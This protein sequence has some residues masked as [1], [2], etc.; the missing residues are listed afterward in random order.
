LGVV[1]GGAPPVDVVLAGAV[2][3]V[4]VEELLLVRGQRLERVLGV[5]QTVALGLLRG[6]C[7]LELLAL[8][9]ELVRQLLQPV[10]LAG[11]ALRRRLR[12]LLGRADVLHVLD[13]GDGGA[14]RVGVAVDVRG[15]GTDDVAHPFRF[16]AGGIELLLDGLDLGGQRRELLRRLLDL[17]GELG[18]HLLVLTHLVGQGGE[19]VGVGL[20]G[21]RRRRRR[22]GGTGRR[23]GGG[24][25]RRRGRGGRRLLRDRGG[26]RD[27]ERADQH[28]RDHCACA[29]HAPVSAPGPRSLSA[30][31]TARLRPG[32]SSS[33]GE[34][35]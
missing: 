29:E 35:A 12:V 34:S 6:A 31:P 17:R 30:H 16:G 7:L 18:E 22:G 21:G 3:D 11:V 1:D 4:V 28:T 14:R 9:G 24:G 15:A 25:G 5:L 13:V 32:A 27:E 26:R 10:D 2:V 19:G 8:R 33:R 23:R 20:G